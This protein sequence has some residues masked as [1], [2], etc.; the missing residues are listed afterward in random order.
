MTANTAFAL[1][2]SPYIVHNLNLILDE[3]DTKAP[4]IKELTVQAREIIKF[5]T[6]HHQSQAIS[7]DLHH[8][9]PLR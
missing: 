7:L 9:E 6:N 2:P 8:V 1:Q 5:I 3:I 4:L